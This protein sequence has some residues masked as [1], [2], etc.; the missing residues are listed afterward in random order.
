MFKYV[1]WPQSEHTKNVASKL[2]QR[3]QL[4]GSV[5]MYI[6]AGLNLLHPQLSDGDVK[7]YYD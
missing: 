5:L 4:T 3:A 6:C 2:G 1:L 7:M